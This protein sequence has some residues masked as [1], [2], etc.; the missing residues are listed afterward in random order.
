MNGMSQSVIYNAIAYSITGT[1][2]YSENAVSFIDTFFLSEET[3]MTPHVNFGQ[4][5]RGIGPE[6]RKGTFTGV[7]DMRGMVKVA[8]AIMALKSS[9]SPHW[10]SNRDTAMKVWMAKYVN[11]LE[12][13]DIPKKTAKSAK[14][15]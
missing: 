2:G 12:T 9:K 11:W 3:A 15:V 1:P 7:L 5:V 14:F 6:H 13:D 10:D 4:I 8:N